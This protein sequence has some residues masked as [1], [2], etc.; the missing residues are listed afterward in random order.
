MGSTLTQYKPHKVLLNVV[1]SLGY[2]IKAVSWKAKKPP[3]W[4]E[5]TLLRFHT[6]GKESNKSF[7]AKSRFSSFPPGRAI[8]GG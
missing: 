8:S 1:N 4:F 7:T 5:A 2:K 3:P 6:V